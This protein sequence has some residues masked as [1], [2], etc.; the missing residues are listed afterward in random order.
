MLNELYQLSVVLEDKGIKPYDWH[1][2]LKLLPN[3]S[4]RKPCYRILISPDSSISGIEPM[5]KVLVSSLR[6]WQ[7]G[8]NGFSFPGFNILPFYCI[9][10]E[11]EKKLLEKLNKG[12][13]K[14]DKRQLTEWCIIENETKYNKKMLNEC[15]GRIPQEL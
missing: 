9:A 8:S 5:E 14:L 1:K 10:G 15:L 7:D 4:D 12:K 2:D 3:T 13:E 11:E 6:K